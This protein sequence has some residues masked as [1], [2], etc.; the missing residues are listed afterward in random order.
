[1]LLEQRCSVDE[2]CNVDGWVLNEEGLG[3]LAAHAVAVH[4]EWLVVSGFC[5]QSPD[6]LVRLVHFEASRT[7]A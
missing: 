2:P 5:E 3:E 6:V 1:V 4:E 7:E